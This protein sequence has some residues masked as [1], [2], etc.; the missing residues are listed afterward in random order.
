M[1]KQP[2]TN[3]NLRKR[4]AALN[5][6]RKQ[7]TMQYHALSAVSCDDRIAERPRA[8]QIVMANLDG[9]GELVHVDNNLPD[10]LEKGVD[11]L[12]DVINCLNRELGRKENSAALGDGTR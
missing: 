9:S 10:E 7:L 5:H 3:T 12:S 4:R 8:K 1:S 6:I 11:M 2:S